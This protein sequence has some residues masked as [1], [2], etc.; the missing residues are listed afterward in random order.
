MTGEMADII[1]RQIG[2]TCRKLRVPGNLI[3]SGAEYNW[4]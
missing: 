2:S 3:L 4:N 1:A